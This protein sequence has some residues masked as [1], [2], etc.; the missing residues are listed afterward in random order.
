[1]LLFILFLF[2]QD[3]PL[4]L[5]AQW[6]REEVVAYLKRATDSN[7]LEVRVCETVPLR[8]VVMSSGEAPTL[9]DN[10]CDFRS[11]TS[12]SSTHERSLNCMAL[13]TGGVHI[14]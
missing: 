4:D 13:V 9:T 14:C 10:S 5:A 3:T 11:S 2:Y 6:G 8:I 1:M 12:E 7:M